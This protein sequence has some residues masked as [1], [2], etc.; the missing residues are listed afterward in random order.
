[1]HH[2]WDLS[3]T[4]AVAL[5]RELRTRVD[6]SRWGGRPRTIGG[7]DISY[8]R[9]S[10]VIYAAIV[11]LDYESQEVIRRST[12]E[13][14]MTFPY[15]PG[16]LSFREIPSLYKAWEALEGKPDVMMMDG[17]GIAHPR[18]LGI[19]THFG[20]LTGVPT[21]GCGKT[22]LLGKFDE[23][24]PARGSYSE[25]VD[26]GEV[27]AYALRTKNRVK[28]VYT[29]PGNGISLEEA[30]DITLHCARGYRIPE[31][32]RQ[33]HLLANALRRGEVT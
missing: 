25:M 6:T 30:R 2:R 11:V 14:K 12:V 20:L 28:P 24:A 32:T 33:A 1:M 10:D 17:H 16:L 9:F 27:V 15:V 23:P 29:G 5:Q 13:D 3:P 8:N 22:V 18:R 26:R 21:I 7:A 31:P 4:E 19:A